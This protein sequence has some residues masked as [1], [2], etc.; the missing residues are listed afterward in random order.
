MEFTN[1]PFYLCICFCF[2]FRIRNSDRYIGQR[3]KSFR[4]FSK[5]TETVFVLIEI[6]YYL[7]FYN[8]GKY[9]YV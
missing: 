9:L 6:T 1:S 8:D 4:T 2:V 7:I 3:V 5:G